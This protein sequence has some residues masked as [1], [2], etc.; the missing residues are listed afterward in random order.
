MQLP[1]LGAFRVER[2]LREAGARRAVA[3]RYSTGS[4]FA[5]KWR[6]NGACSTMR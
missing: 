3:A 2:R 1:G 4:S 5:E 6:R